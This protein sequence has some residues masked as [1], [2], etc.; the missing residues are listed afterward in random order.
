[1]CSN[2]TSRRNTPTSNTPLT[3]VFTQSIVKCSP[4]EFCKDPTIIDAQIAQIV[5]LRYAQYMGNHLKNI[6]QPNLY[7]NPNC[8]LC[9]NNTI[10]TW[11]HLLSTSSN[12]HIKWLHIAH[13][14]KAIHQIIH[15]LHPIKHMRYY[16]LIN[17]GNQY[18]TPQDNTIPQW[19][20]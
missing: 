19:F 3:H 8:T 16:T 9:P 11:P 10:D 18:S 5:K 2:L 17:A 1:M 13:D 15:M 6:F 14:N 7:P 4:R 12:P 20:L